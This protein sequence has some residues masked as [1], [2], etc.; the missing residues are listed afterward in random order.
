M[1]TTNKLLELQKALKPVKKDLT[2]PYFK[3][4]YADINAFL[5]EV[6]PKLSDVG[7]FVTQPLLVKE[8]R[9]LLVTQIWDGKELLLA[10]DVML[11]DNLKPQELGSAITYYRRYSLQ[12]LLCLEAED[13]D[14]NLPVAKKPV[15]FAAKTQEPDPRTEDVQ[16][17][18]AAKKAISAASTATKLKNVEKRITDS[19][20]LST[21]E[22]DALYQLVDEKSNFLSQ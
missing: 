22:K 12:S 13:N 2:N 10:S 4:K 1:I 21:E 6:K 17:F 11:P 7:L 19:T 9:N 8:G 18:E 14:G 20:N 15:T 16:P 5:E 3:S